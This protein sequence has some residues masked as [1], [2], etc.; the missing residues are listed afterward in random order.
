MFK[1]EY[2]VQGHRAHVEFGNVGQCHRV[3]HAHWCHPWRI[4]T[5]IKVI[6]RICVSSHRLRD[7]NVS[8][9]QG[10]RVQHLKRF[11][12][13]AN[14]NIHNSRSTRFYACCYSFWDIRVWNFIPWKFRSGSRS[15]IIAMVSFDWNINVYKKIILWHFCQL[16]PFSR[17]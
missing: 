16:S 14:C 11:R 12:S 6:A 10:H 8:N 17:Y 15:T 1:L 3:Q 5:S 4:S 2:L 7:N 13:V 9:I